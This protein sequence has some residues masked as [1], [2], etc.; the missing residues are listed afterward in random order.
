MIY[1]GSRVK[2]DMSLGLKIT[3]DLFFDFKRHTQGC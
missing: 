2:S 3:A 1:Y